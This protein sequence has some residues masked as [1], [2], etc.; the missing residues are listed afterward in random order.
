MGRDERGDFILKRMK[1]DY[2]GGGVRANFLSTGTIASGSAETGRA[3][4]YFNGRMRRSLAGV[5]A[6]YLGNF[7]VSQVGERGSGADDV[8][9]MEY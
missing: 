4:M 3:E 6:Q 5:T 7:S 2:K 1:Q 9:E 8:E